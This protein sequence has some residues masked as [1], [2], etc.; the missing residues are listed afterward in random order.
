MSTTYL[1]YLV[2]SNLVSVDPDNN[3][4]FLTDVVRRD[5]M[6]SLVLT[7]PVTMDRIAVGL[8]TTTWEDPAPGMIYIYH[9]EYA[10]G[11]VTVPVVG[12]LQGQG[13]SSTEA[14]SDTLLPQILSR[15]PGCSPGFALQ[16]LYSIASEFCR[17]SEIWEAESSITSEE[18][19]DTYTVPVS[20]N[21]SILRVLSVEQDDAATGYSLNRNNELVLASPATADDVVYTVKYVVCPSWELDE[22][23]DWLLQR[24]G[25]TIVCGALAELMSQENRPWSSNKWQDYRA[26]YLSGLAQAKAECSTER[27][28]AP[29][30]LIIPSF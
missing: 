19:E 10:L 5:T 22:Y 28:P 2:R 8:Y 24:C 25:F 15:V 30:Q 9:L 14:A 17:E 16:V 21:T 27:D 26:R 4:M 29:A 6:E 20:A 1:Q 11:G 3:E 13:G 12:V 23:P 18:D 7:F